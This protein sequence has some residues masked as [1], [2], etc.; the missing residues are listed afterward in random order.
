MRPM[1]T[2]P[3][4]P[5]RN[6]CVYCGSSPGDDP[7]FVEAANE[8]GTLLAAADIRLVYGGGDL[9]LMGA[10]AHGVLAGGGKVIGVIPEFL[11][12]KEQPEGAERLKSAEMVT[13][14]DMHT[15]K[16]MMFEQADAFIALP[17]GIGTLEELIEMLTWAQ[18]ARHTKPIAVLNTKGFW[19]PLI[20]LIDHMESAG[21][22]HNPGPARPL[23]CGTP[24]EFMEKTKTI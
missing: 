6:V 14:P 20:E 13:V 8:L 7:S 17:G 2:P 19:D 3:P 21:F 9:G 10:V 15:R 12:S 16:Q 23:V 11:L 1:V 24:T 4:Q 5:I 22:L 18:L